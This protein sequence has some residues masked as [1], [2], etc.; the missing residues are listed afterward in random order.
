MPEYFKKM[1]NSLCYCYYL[2]GTG[3]ERTLK[4]DEDLWGRG[5]NK[6]NERVATR[7]KYLNILPPNPLP[8]YILFVSFK[9]QKGAYFCMQ[10]GSP[11]FPC[12][13]GTGLKSTPGWLREDLKDCD[14]GD[15][16]LGDPLSGY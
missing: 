3:V 1:L 7:K 6:E 13:V 4:Q 14:R 2:L 10:S 15:S 16:D 8:F 12:V 5:E 9:C 11:Y